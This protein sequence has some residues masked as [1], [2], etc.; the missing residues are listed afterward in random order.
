M[1]LEV[2]ENILENEYRSFIE[3]F[4]VNAEK[5]VPYSLN[6][7]GLS[8]E[9]YILTLTDEALGK[10]IAQNWVPASTYF[11]VNNQAKICGAINIRH[12]LTDSL[13]IEGGHIGYGIR[14][15]CRNLGYGTAILTKGLAILKAMDINKA[16]LTC[17]RDNVNSAAVIKNNGGI[18]ESE[19]E[20][21][22]TIVQR[23]WI[24]L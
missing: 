8:F 2:P 6:Q 4:K 15:S 24:A 12:R 18:L 5:L 1:K 19:V 3:E 13:L 20:V 10:N 11:L 9:R 23:Y 16:L 17:D 21:S 14:P 7:K 22:S